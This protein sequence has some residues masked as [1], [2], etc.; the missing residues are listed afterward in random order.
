L[1]NRLM[2]VGSERELKN[3]FSEY[4]ELI[5][6]WDQIAQPAGGHR[7]APARFSR[8]RIKIQEELAQAPQEVQ[9]LLRKLGN[10]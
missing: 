2:S 9:D 5:P 8:S 6:I 4:P 10:E 1:F 3:L 7:T